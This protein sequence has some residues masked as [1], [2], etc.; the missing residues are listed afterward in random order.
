ML[1]DAAGAVLATVPREEVRVSVSWKAYVFDDEAEERRWKE[2]E[3]LLS[4]PAVLDTFERRLAED[5]LLPPSADA[6]AFTRAVGA[7]MWTRKTGA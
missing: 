4:V 5:G 6:D 7:K 1:L 3:E 2:S